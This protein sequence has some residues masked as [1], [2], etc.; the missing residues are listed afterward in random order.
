MH[1]A[2]ALGKPI[3]CFFGHSNRN[4]W[5]PWKTPYVLL[6]PE[7]KRVQ[8]ISVDDALAAFF[9]LQESI[10]SPEDTATD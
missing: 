4:E 6:Q 1:V 2:A 5:H 3:V 7:S 9:A 10:L 8:D